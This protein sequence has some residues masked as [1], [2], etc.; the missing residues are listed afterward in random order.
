MCEG[1]GPFSVVCGEEREQVP[2]LEPE[3]GPALR[4]GHHAW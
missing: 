4:P 1:P 3:I 2:P